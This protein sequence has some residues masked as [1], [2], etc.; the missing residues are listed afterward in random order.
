MKKV[1][2]GLSFIVSVVIMTTLL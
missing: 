2:K 1:L